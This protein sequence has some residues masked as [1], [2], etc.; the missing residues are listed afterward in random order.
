MR[1]GCADKLEGNGG[2]PG[3]SEE[4]FLAMEEVFRTRLLSVKRVS[5]EASPLVVTLGAL[6]PNSSH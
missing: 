4:E 2:E 5:V 1:L 3:M 6:G